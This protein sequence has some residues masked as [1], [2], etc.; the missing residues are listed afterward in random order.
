MFTLPGSVKKSLIASW[1]IKSDNKEP[2]VV[3]NIVFKINDVLPNIK[4]SIKFYVF[5]HYNTEQQ[6]KTCLKILL[7]HEK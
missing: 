3:T 7:N 6:R 2:V 4:K 1:S 5:A